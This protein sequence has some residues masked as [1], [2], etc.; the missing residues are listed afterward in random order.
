MLN[1]ILTGLGVVLAIGIVACF[2]DVYARLAAHRQEFRDILAHHRKTGEE[3]A[4]LRRR[5]DSLEQT[6]QNTREFWSSDR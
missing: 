4:R 5:L 1:A 3:L 2:I 6:R